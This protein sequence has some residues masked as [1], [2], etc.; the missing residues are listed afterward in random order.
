MVE[1]IATIDMI[2]YECGSIPVLRLVGE[3]VHEQN[4]GRTIEY[5]SVVYATPKQLGLNGS[6]VDPAKMRFMV[7]VERVE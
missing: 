7:T 4:C 2:N 5:E 6:C 3:T 1:F